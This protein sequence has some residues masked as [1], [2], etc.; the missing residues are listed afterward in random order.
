MRFLQNPTDLNPKMG[1]TAPSARIVVLH[2]HGTKSARHLGQSVEYEPQIMVKLGSLY[3]CNRC[4]S[5]LMKILG[6][7]AMSEQRKARWTFRDDG[8]FPP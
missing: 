4:Q 2:A 1:T 8:S 3:D 7:H 5:F 6:G